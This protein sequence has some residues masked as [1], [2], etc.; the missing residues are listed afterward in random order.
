MHILPV[1]TSRI[2][3]MISK[4]KFSFGT[5]NIMAFKSEFKFRTTIINADLVQVHSVSIVVVVD[6]RSVDAYVHER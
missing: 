2:Q 4:L 5:I 3:F 1:I 6:F